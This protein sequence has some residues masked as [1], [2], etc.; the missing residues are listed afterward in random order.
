MSRARAA[1]LISV[2][3]ILSVGAF[4][5]IRARM[6]SPPRL[7]VTPRAGDFGTLDPNT[8]ATLHLTLANV[9]GDTLVI[10]RIRSECACTTTKLAT[11]RLAPGETT[12][13]DVSFD[14]TGYM[15]SVRKTLV[16]ETNDPQRQSFVMLNAYVKVGVRTSSPR[17]T[18]GRVRPFEEVSGKIDLY[19]DRGEELAQVRCEGLT[20]EFESRLGARIPWKDIDRQEIIISL[21]ALP[22]KAGRYTHTASIHPGNSEPISLT[23]EYE[24]LPAMSCSPEVATLSPESEGTEIRL[25]W[26]P[27]LTVSNV[28]P[29]SIYGKVHASIVSLDKGRCTMVIAPS[30]PSQAR[31]NTDLDVLVI[32]F[33][34][35]HS[36]GTNGFDDKLVVPIRFH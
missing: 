1:L 14:S 19:Y 25:T 11:R 8:K 18:F 16:I 26:P 27:S 21:A 34:V 33:T 32:K 6:G 12:D 22:K 4:A 10:R 31:A 17:L 7:R 36:E 2:I 3:V 24:L 29:E 28:S 15:R 20:E 30:P 35:A 9:G 5:W 13:M 23:L